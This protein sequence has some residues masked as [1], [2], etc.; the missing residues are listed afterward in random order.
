MIPLAGDF[1]ILND[2]VGD[3]LQPVLS[4]EIPELLFLSSLFVSEDVAKNNDFGNHTLVQYF[5]NIPRL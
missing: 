3:A 1:H 4:L 2:G 5:G